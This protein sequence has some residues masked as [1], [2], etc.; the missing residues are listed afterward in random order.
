MFWNSLLALSLLAKITP[1]HVISELVPHG[2]CADLYVMRNLCSTVSLRCSFKLSISSFSGVTYKRLFQPKAVIRVSIT[3]P[4]P[5]P[6]DDERARVLNPLL[7]SR[8][9]DLQPMETTLI[10]TA[11]PYS[12]TSMQTFSQSSRMK[13]ATKFTP[14]CKFSSLGKKFCVTSY[15]L[16]SDMNL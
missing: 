12:P 11:A 6:D 10:P 3:L 8:N 5:L 7:G 15:R 14:S 16:Q 2:A 1:V 4:I 9:T 13:P